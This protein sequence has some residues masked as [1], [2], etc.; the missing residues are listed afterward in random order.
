MAINTCHFNIATEGVRSCHPC[1]IA[2]MG[3]LGFDV[4]VVVTPP[5]EKRAY[6]P[7]QIGWEEYN[8]NLGDTYIV[9]IKVTYKNRIWK[10]ERLISE[11]LFDQLKVW[12]R[13]LRFERAR[14]MVR[15]SFS[16]VINTIKVLAT[17]KG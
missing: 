1:T 17:R 4:T 13:F 5:R 12:A 14:T 3:M 2:S 6:H 7:D 16:K 11:P 8:G 10:M 15:A 9:T